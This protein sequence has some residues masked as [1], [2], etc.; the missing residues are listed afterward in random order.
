MLASVRRAASEA[1]GALYAA[2]G[3]LAAVA[4]A[5]AAFAA[6]REAQRLRRRAAEVAAELARA[7]QPPGE[8]LSAARLI[9]VLEEVRLAASAA[10]A[11]VEDAL[12][13]SPPPEDEEEALALAAAARAQVQTQC[14]AAQRRAL[15]SRGLT[16]EACAHALA[17]YTA[18]ANANGDGGGGGGR[19]GQRSA[20]GGA[21]AE[22]A[23]VGSAVRLKRT[24][25]RFFLTKQR[26]L[27]VFEEAKKV[28]VRLSHQI[29]DSV[30]A[31]HELPV[32]RVITYLQSEQ[33]Q[34]A[35]GRAADQHAVFET[36][37]TIEE[38]KAVMQAPDWAGD[39]AF[40]RAFDQ[41]S[42]KSEALMEHS[43]QDLMRKIE[44]YR[45]EMEEGG[46]G[47][48]G[49]EDFGDEEGGGGGPMNAEMQRMIQQ[50]I[51]FARM[52]AALR[53]RLPQRKR[54]MLELGAQQLG[55]PLAP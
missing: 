52:P 48:R 45:R 23:V 11:K 49:A 7:Q 20:S 13:V 16:A 35:L 2:A 12:R 6:A 50:V 37:L 55:V 34:E 53:A 26:V 1:G 14:A 5:A 29:A 33:A 17:F 15:E 41:L 22:A 9:E 32:A 25:G 43:D 31:P 51:E 46:A 40:R 4:L 28:Q 21:G 42:R 10:V 38:L 3:P 19:A 44:A 54:E 30:M 27:Q 36:G 8:G 47:Q 39:V 18:L 24:V